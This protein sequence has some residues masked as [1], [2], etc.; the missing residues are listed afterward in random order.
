MEQGAKLGG[1]VE[2]S[3]VAAVQ[4]AGTSSKSDGNKLDDG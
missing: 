3:V 4:G 2:R 1:R